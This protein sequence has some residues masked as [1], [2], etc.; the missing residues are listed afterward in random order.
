MGVPI[1]SSDV[2][3]DAVSNGVTGLLVTPGKPILLAEAI[4]RLAASPESRL[5]MG[6]AA[7]ERIRAEYSDQHVNNLWIAEYQHLIAALGPAAAASPRDM[8]LRNS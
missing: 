3:L 4:L 6:A 5:Q 7:I 1:V 8:T 2:G